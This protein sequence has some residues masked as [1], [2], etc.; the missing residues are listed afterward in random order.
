MGCRLQ[1][2]A[3]KNPAGS[4]VIFLA[5]YRDITRQRRKQR[6][7]LGRSQT[8]TRCWAEQARTGPNFRQSPR[9][10]ITDNSDI[11]VMRGRRA[12]GSICWHM[13]THCGGGAANIFKRMHSESESPMQQQ[14]CTVIPVRRTG[15]P[16]TQTQSQTVYTC[17][18]FRA[19]A[20]AAWCVPGRNGPAS[21]SEFE[22]Q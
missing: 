11:V 3:Y 9:D 6:S 1:A 4:S 10:M 14:S 17:K 7:C 19:A 13:R 5:A 16:Q 8:T 22:G 20:Q 12:H 18:Y 2:E 15:V 21:D